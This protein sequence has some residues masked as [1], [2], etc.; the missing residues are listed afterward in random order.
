MIGIEGSIQT[1]KYTDNSGNNRTVFEVVA[2]N[3]HFAEKRD[4]SAA[5]AN[6]G[7]AA[8]PAPS[9]SNTGADDFSELPGEDD[10]PF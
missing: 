8:A 5:P 6:D 4:A 7:F 1:R 3:V 2:N 10:L 9:F